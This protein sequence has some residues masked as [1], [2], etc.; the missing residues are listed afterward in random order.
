[1]HTHRHA[2]TRTD[3]PPHPLSGWSG[4]PGALPSLSATGGPDSGQDADDPRSHGW[5]AAGQVCG[6]LAQ[7][8]ARGPR[9]SAKPS[10]AVRDRIP[11]KDQAQVCVPDLRPGGAAAWSPWGT[12]RLGAEDPLLHSSPAAHSSVGTAILHGLRRTGTP[13]RDRPTCAC[14]W[15][16]RMPSAGQPWNVTGHHRDP[17]VGP[18]VSTSQDQRVRQQPLPICSP[19][20][21]KFP[22]R[23]QGG[24]PRPS[25]SPRPHGGGQPSN[26]N[27]LAHLRAWRGWNRSGP[28]RRR[29]RG[30]PASS[31]GCN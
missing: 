10:P 2:C 11:D 5:E 9:G 3:T 21:G 7:K 31:R 27:D 25:P 12:P 13:L 16:P 26:D 6:T 19:L 18:P 28:S 8:S 22:K 1:M 14:L 4:Q 20:E 15:D 30:V 17:K 23:K 24:T 29:G